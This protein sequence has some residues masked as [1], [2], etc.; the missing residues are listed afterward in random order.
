MPSH[1]AVS[2][3]NEFV[4]RHGTVRPAQMKLQKLVY[5]AH[6][7]NLAINQEPLANTLPEAW[8]G[9][10]VFRSIWNH[11]RDYGYGA[12]SG[13][14]ENT[15]GKPLVARLVEAEKDVVEMVWDKYRNFTGHELSQMTHQADTPWS[16]A[17]LSRGQN[18]AISNKI[19]QSYFRRLGLAGR[20]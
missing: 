12:K 9:G 8:D 10:P 3:A 7:W 14:L 20:D 6:G 18:A 11:I 13:L 15:E 17:Y 4:R 1:S 16:E 5:H 19:M 2:I